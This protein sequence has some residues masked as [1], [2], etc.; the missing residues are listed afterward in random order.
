M[1]LFLHILD[2]KFVSSRRPTKLDPDRQLGILT[3]SVK[4]YQPRYDGVEWIRYAVGLVAD[5]A[6]LD[7]TLTSNTLISSWADLLTQQPSLYIRLTRSIDLS[8]SQLKIPDE[9][10]FPVMLR[11]VL[12]PN[13]RLLRAP[14]LG[15]DDVAHEAQSAETTSLK[16]VL[17]P[18]SLST[19]EH[20]SH[21][22]IDVLPITYEES[23]IASE[24]SAAETI[25]RN[26]DLDFL[27]LGDELAQS[28]GL[29][30]DDTNTLQTDNSEQ[31]LN[32]MVGSL[33]DACNYDAMDIQINSMLV[34][35]SDLD[36]CLFTG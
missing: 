1:P 34:N 35:T 18:S 27:A 5:L 10:D 30:L 33:I 32:D 11:G 19:P 26:K 21:E 28:P 31:L 25:P 3:D 4:V 23:I 16:T 17:S 36:D 2:A 13:M 20:T 15:I 8:I 9:K 6:Q 22:S 29:T 12:S 14:I 24:V 7:S